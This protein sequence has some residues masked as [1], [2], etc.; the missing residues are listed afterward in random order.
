MVESPGSDFLTSA[1]F[2]NNTHYQGRSMTGRT[3]THVSGGGLRSCAAVA[4]ACLAGFLSEP[5]TARSGFDGYWSVEALVV[6]GECG[7]STFAIQVS[8]GAVTFAGLGATAKG[9]IGS[10]GRLRASI[11]DGENVVLAK[12]ALRGTIGSGSWSSPK[13]TGRWIARRG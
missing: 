9:A 10:N 1:G 4:I 12:G 2:N 8:D 6:N 13:C 7:A 5:A 3:H 11:T